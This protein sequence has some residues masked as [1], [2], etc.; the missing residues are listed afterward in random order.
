MSLKCLYLMICWS[1]LYNIDALLHLSVNP[2]TVE[3]GLTTTITINCSLDV[4]SEPDMS[5]LES[6]KL[7]RSNDTTP[8][9]YT[10]L[11]T[12]DTFSNT[13]T[14]SSDSA[15]N[16]YG[17]IDTS[18]VSYLSLV[19]NKPIEFLGGIFKCEVSSLDLSGRPRNENMTS[20]VNVVSAGV[21]ELLVRV[22]SLS[23]VIENMST[24][25]DSYTNR[26]LQSKK[27][28]FLES[29]PFEGSRYY[30][31]RPFPSLVSYIAQATC[32]IYG[33][34][35]AQV[36]SQEELSFIQVFLQEFFNSFWLVLIGGTDEGH[37]DLWVYPESN[38]NVSFFAW[39]SYQPSGG[40]KENC[41]SLDTLA[42]WNMSDSPC[43]FTDYSARPRFLCEIPEI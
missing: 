38:R 33:G 4:L 24:V 9:V 41:I 16:A 10:T 34:T 14:N 43:S 6:I 12:I 29:S 21:N 37:E 27:S 36:D 2:P 18:G 26:L 13:A 35:L 42:Y 15:A 11:S 22:Q 23:L 8:P 20:R 32:E 1:T 17:K 5:S 7:S 3:V 31:S 25:I 30:L 28:L 19:W 40:E 39:G